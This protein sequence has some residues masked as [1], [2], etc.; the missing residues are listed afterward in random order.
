MDFRILGR[1][2]VVDGGVDVAPRRA[3]PRVVLAM[4]LLH[5]NEVLT[6]DRLIDALW[7]DA[8]PATA[9]KALQGHVSVLRKVLGFDRLATERGGYRLDVRPGELDVDRFT[10]AVSAAR[11]QPDAAARARALRE[12]LATWRGEPLSDLG[13]ERSLQPEIARLAALRVA[14]LEAWAEAE[15]AAGNH[16]AVLAD[17][18]R[19]VAEHPLSEGLR[20]D[21]MLALYRA[22]RQSDALRT[23]RDGRRLLAEELGIDP[24]TQLQVLERQILAHDPALD[25]APATDAAPAPRQERKTVTVLVVEV[26]P[27]GATDPEDL[28]E[29]AQPALDRIRTLVEQVGGRAEPL[30]A[31]ALVGMFGA[32]RAHDDDALRAVRTA[33]DLLAATVAGV[34]LRG[35][36]ETG[37]ALVTI[38]GDDVSITGQVL[39]AASR[40][41]VN[42]PVGTILVG[43]AT[44]RATAGAVDYEPVDAGAWVPR[45]LL[46]VDRRTQPEPLFVGRADELGQLDRI[47]ARAH[48]GR[49]VQ[50]VTITAEPGGGKSRLV[51]ELRGR[52]DG[53]RGDPSAGAPRWLQGRC[54][55]YGNGLTFWAL[56]EVIKDWA[57]ILETDDSAVSA[58]KL[59]LALGALEPDDNRRTWLARSVAPLAGIDDAAATGDREQ[60]FAAWRQLVEAIA[61]EQPLVIVFE[62][63]HWADDALLAFIDH[64]VQHAADV[65]IVVL[66]TARPELF[67][68]HPTWSAGRRN[69]TNLL[70]PP[71]SEEDTGQ[72]LHALLGRTA[73]PDMIKRAG[74]NPLY[75]HELA[76][77][78]ADPDVDAGP[79]PASLQAVIAAHLDA[80]APD[81]KVA[82]ANAAVVGEVFWPGIVA[83]I[84]GV[85]PAIVETRLH[86]LVANEVIRRRRRSTVAGQEE[87][88]FL[89]VLVRDVAYG[90][91]PRRD[92]I[93]KHR[94]TAAW[95]E[96][97]AEDRPTAHAELASH[98]YVEALELAQRLGDH[99]QVP[100]LRVRA[101]ASLML[102]GD[103][104][105]TLDVAKAE[106]L[107]RRAL[108]LAT[109]DDPVRGRLLGRLGVVTQFTG[110]P[111]EA[112]ALCR[113]A[114]AALS[115][116]GD[117]EGAASVMVHLVSILWRLGRPEGERRRILLDAIEI[118]EAAPPGA[119]IVNAY[120]QM[121]ALELYEGRVPATLEWASK[122]LA[123]ADRLGIPVLQ[124][125]P[126]HY[127]GIARFEMGDLGGIGD[128]RTA[129]RLGLEAGLGWEV[130]LVATDLGA[131]LWLSE[132]PAAGLEAKQFAASFCVDRGLMYLERT[133]RA[134]SL[135]LRFDAGRWD[136][137]I[138]D[139]DAL[140]E[141]ERDRGPARITMIALTAKARVLAERGRVVEALELEP[142]I[143]QRAR[144]LGDSQD[145]VP[146]FATAAAIRSAAG[147]RDAALG[148]IGELVTELLDRDP[149][150]RAHELPVIVRVA[151]AGGRPELGRELAPDDEPPYERARLCVSTGW[152]ELA[153][154]D[155]NLELA[156]EQ[157]SATAA[158]WAAYGC[159]LE[160]ALAHIGAARCQ[161]ALGR[162]ELAREPIARARALAHALGAAP[163]LSEIAR[164][165]AGLEPTGASA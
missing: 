72:L 15:V 36:I 25:L 49:S 95:I 9:D 82:A 2:E 16:A 150:K 125:E 96:R 22:G 17:L 30:F 139:A 92:R 94:A 155:G 134:E 29:A 3:Q 99:E 101:V 71:L 159:P 87:Y 80:L 138:E 104:A 161:A 156:V 153:E 8:P 123:V 152:A 164:L 41:Q 81:L 141:W 77:L 45:G 64:L 48:D 12:A 63:I 62:D 88:E 97:L 56:G 46:S 35:G 84:G 53:E 76:R 149:P 136:E 111:A 20:A 38:D 69:A 142:E 146:T 132:G 47:V 59:T 110:R 100:E 131:T 14:A 86:R 43:P 154:A 89:H 106:S 27:A 85:E 105:R 74:G 135:W 121:A 37:E 140:I 126:L 31:N 103:G 42:A 68:S 147:D 102:A 151:V 118:L 107:Y 143:L 163:L 157:H 23:F 44:Q 120:S 129:V 19:L 11:A 39:G 61:A 66:C 7:G 55:P 52:L 98:H 34:E 109:N 112:E 115:S 51:R 24:G 65:P 75:A 90:Q 70:L 60:G 54:L 79:I 127:I 58:D 32:P 73:T 4:L 137:V 18:E 26:V 67:E 78:I 50:L 13:N 130:G 165:E 40:L 158:G 160:E 21:H 144:A 83:E 148:L 10:A 116:Q 28:E 128:I 5:P 124:L 108:A 1:L 133:T 122:G 6:T 114:I 33:L 117:S 113:E 93:A 119:E 145:L 57:G 162:P 91:I